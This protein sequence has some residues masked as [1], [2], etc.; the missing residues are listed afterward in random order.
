MKG[1]DLKALRRK[2]GLTQEGLS[3]LTGL[4][5]NIISQI[6]QERRYEPEYFGKVV[7]VLKDLESKQVIPV[8]ESTVCMDSSI[9]EAMV[10]GVSVLSAQINERKKFMGIRREE[11]LLARLVDFIAKY[12][13]EKGI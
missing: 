1:K 3:L 13:K 10:W 12:E 5:Q 2:V 8:K 11:K 4:N 6:E 7:D 9:Y